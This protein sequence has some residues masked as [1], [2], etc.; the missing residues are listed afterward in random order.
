[1]PH[2]HLFQFVT[3]DSLDALQ[4]IT[5]TLQGCLQLAVL[6]LQLV[7][8]SQALLLGIETQGAASGDERGT[9]ASS[10]PWSVTYSALL[11][12]FLDLLLQAE[13]GSTCV[14]ATLLELSLQVAQCIL[15][16]HTHA[17]TTT[18]GV[19]T[20]GLETS[21]LHSRVVGVCGEV[22]PDGASQVSGEHRAASLPCST[23]QPDLIVHAIGILG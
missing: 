13:A 3:L 11:I 14:A 6:A 9:V 16:T 21:S 22:Y 20:S 4:S 8:N 5:F 10:Q 18:Q 12:A 15:N 2:T 19:R 17:H 7:N 1:M 23:V